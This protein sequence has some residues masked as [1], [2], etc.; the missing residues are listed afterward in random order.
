MLVVCAGTATEVG[1]TFVGAAAL[2]ELGARGRTVAARKPAQSFD[3][4]DGQPLDAVVL[5]DATGEAPDQVCPPARTYPVAM[6]PPMAAAALDV[7]VPTLRDLLGELSWP[8]PLPEVCWLETVGGPRSPI[9][10]DG[11][12]VDLVA[13]LHPDAI[14]LVADA[15][16]GTI[17][18]VLLSLAPLR[19][20][21]PEP[22]VVLNRFDAGDDLH[23]R[24]AEWLARA[25]VRLVGDVGALVDVLDAGG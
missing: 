15:G 22:V 13:Q 16:L 8:T 18:A 10:S 21:G 6:A 4:A 9:A 17:N 25:G 23:R 14:V 11:D 19:D 2:R 24:N 5:A 1:K 12:A 20:V 3:P 7:P